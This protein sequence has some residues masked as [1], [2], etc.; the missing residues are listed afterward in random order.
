LATAIKVFVK[1]EWVV[2]PFA[3]ESRAAAW[4]GWAPE[5][6][7]EKLISKEDVLAAQIANQVAEEHG[8]KLKLYDLAQTKGWIFGHIYHVKTTPTIIINGHR[9]EGVPNKEALSHALE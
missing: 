1:G 3:S 4:S 9:I 6:R 8:L 7:F 2:K 5:H